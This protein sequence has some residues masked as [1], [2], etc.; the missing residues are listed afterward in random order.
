M[1]IYFI[2]RPSRVPGRPFRADKWPF[3]ARSARL[4][5]PPRPALGRGGGGVVGPGVLGVAAAELLPDL[6]VGGLPEARE[7]LRH[8]L[9]AAVRG[10]EVE[11][12]GDAAG[13]D[14]RRRAPAEELLDA[15]R[16]DRRPA[17]LVGEAELA[18]GG[19]AEA[20]RGLALERMALFAI[21]GAGEG[22]GERRLAQL[23]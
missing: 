13:G 20:L 18:A 19:D 7:V 11:E 16:Q 5:P 17:R 23:G 22:L 4:R 12:D 1:A 21:E 10:E 9:R 15:R 2:F 3:I 8:L 14:A 6:G